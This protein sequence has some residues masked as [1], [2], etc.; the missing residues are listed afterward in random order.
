[1]E[2]FVMFGDTPLF[3]VDE[4]RG[5]AI[6]LLHGYLESSLVWDDFA[7]NLKRTN[8]VVRLDLP[9][10]GLSGEHGDIHT[11]EFLSDAVRHV[12]SLTN[13]SK[14]TLVGHSMGGYVALAFAKKYPELLNGF[15]LFHSTPNPDSEEKKALRSKEIE[16]IQEDKLEL[17]A[18][19]TAPNGFAQDSR[20]RFADFIE[21]C[22]E[23]YS[24]NEK[25]GIIAN[26]EGMKVRED[27]NEFVASTSIPHLFVFGMKDYYIS[28][29]VA[30]GL[31]AKFP[32]AETLLLE[33]SGHM[34]FVEE[35]KKSLE[36]I[37]AFAEKHA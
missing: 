6:V 9:G 12:L 31:V 16:L 18:R 7:A 4:G 25:N 21:E 5:T 10:H 26:L 33:N 37:V 24:M 19:T 22:V 11:M 20:K 3:Y 35:P 2:K 27:M 23:M 15:V 28:R 17:I 29:E 30:E 1:M 32:K 13:V 8:R 34:G 14:C 36:A